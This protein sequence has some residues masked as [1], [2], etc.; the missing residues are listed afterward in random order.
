MRL[1]DTVLPR[2]FGADAGSHPGPSTRPVRSH[3]LAIYGVARVVDDTGD[4]LVG[5]RMG[6]LDAL[7]DQLDRVPGYRHAPRLRPPDPDAPPRAGPGRHAVPCADRGEPRRPGGDPLRHLGVVPRL[8]RA[9]GEPGRA[10]RA[11][12]ARCRH[13][14][15]VAWSRRRLH[16][17]AARRAPAGRG[18]GL[19]PRPRVPSRPRISTGSARRR[20][21]SR[22][23]RHRARSARRRL[24]G[25]PR[26]AAAAP[27]GAAALSE[28][29]GPGAGGGR[30]DRGRW[31]RSPRR[32]RA[33]PLRRARRRTPG[34]RTCARCTGRRRSVSPV[35]SRHAARR[36]VRTLRGDHPQRGEE[37]R[38]RYPPAPSPEAI[39]D[40]G[41]LHVRPPDRRHQR[42]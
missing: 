28:P 18:R 12:G 42:R 23:P 10:S 6:T 33:G 5:D 9:L 13:A 1:D 27:G 2:A 4:E 24:R 25:R 3:L 32:D 8:L 41:D 35:G 39:G 19:R 11:H 40:V 36:R 7:Q 34:P 31:S 14:R 16:R 37:L 38:L 21:I 26:P 29:P 22:P 30:R 15:W 17:V 20:Q